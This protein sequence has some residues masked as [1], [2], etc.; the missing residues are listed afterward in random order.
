MLDDY[1]TDEIFAKKYKHD[2]ALVFDGTYA[3]Y[4]L[5]DAILSDG[6]T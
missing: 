2:G 3:Y 1:K 6:F 5:D 4:E